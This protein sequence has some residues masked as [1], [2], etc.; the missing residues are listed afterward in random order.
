MHIFNV[1][2]IS[3]VL[4]FLFEYVNKNLS[5]SIYLFFILKYLFILYISVFLS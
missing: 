4:T 5:T 1:L 2:M 3:I